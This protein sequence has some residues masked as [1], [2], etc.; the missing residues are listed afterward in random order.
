MAKG[1][2]S[3]FHSI[4]LHFSNLVPRQV[5]GFAD[6]P[7]ND[8][9]RPDHAVLLKQRIC[10]CVSVIVTIVEGQDNSPAWQFNARVLQRLDVAVDRDCVVAAIMEKT[11]LLLE[12]FGWYI[13]LNAELR[14]FRRNVMINNYRNGKRP[15]SGF[16]CLSRR[17]SD[18]A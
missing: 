11:N 5:A 18:Q 3:D 1:V 2:R 16:N 14:H 17:R 15:W 8:V 9:K 12:F 10:L 4:S 13:P 6:V 7:C